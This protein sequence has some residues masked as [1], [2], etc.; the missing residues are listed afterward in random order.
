[1]DAR[2]GG[3]VVADESALMPFAVALRKTPAVV[4]VEVERVGLFPVRALDLIPSEA[5]HA[6]ERTQGVGSLYRVPHLRS[7]FQFNH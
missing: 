6:D 4:V 7:V 5:A 1:M 2:G 3:D